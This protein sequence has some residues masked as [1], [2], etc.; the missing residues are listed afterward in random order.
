LRDLTII[1]FGDGTPICDRRT[2]GLTD[3]GPQHIPRYSMASRSINWIRVRTATAL[4]PSAFI[5]IL[6]QPVLNAVRALHTAN[7]MNH[8]D[9]CLLY[10]R[11]NKRDRWMWR[12]DDSP[13]YRMLPVHTVYCL[14]VL[15]HS[16]LVLFHSH[17]WSDYFDAIGMRAM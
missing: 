5:V 10:Y 1:C 15:F 11:P 7:A 4:V 8:C 14:L 12:R 2:D 3:T 6:R 17:V 16:E 13:T 9:G